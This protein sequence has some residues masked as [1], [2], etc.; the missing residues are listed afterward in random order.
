MQS[1]IKPIS[2]ALALAALLS[3][4]LV[5]C[6]RDA[7]AG[8]RQQLVLTGSSTVAPL[9]AELARRFESTRPDVRVDVQS[10]GSSRG[11]ADARSGHA[12]LG[13]ASRA[14]APSETDLQAHTIARDGVALIV[15]A[16]NQLEGLSSEQVRAIYTGKISDWK[17]LGASPGPITV[18]NK[19]AGR[20]TLAVFLEHF[21]LEARAIKAAIIAGENEQ[22]IKTVAGTRGAIGYV[23]IGTAEVDIEAGVAIKLLAL[24]GVEA[25]SENVAKGRYPL[26]R[27]LNLI[28]SSEPS[29]LALDFIDFAKSSANND[30]VLR[31]AFIPV[32][33]H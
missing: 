5:S 7:A 11:I 25:S 32:A 12:E 16:D 10:G 26:A 2:H 15:H 18:V 30:I 28:T 13:M 24:D 23:S 1:L 19:A 6:T 14:L 22:A 9:A 17:Q 4:S 29:E 27:P 3:S 31:E 33:D 8:T 21:G 20:A